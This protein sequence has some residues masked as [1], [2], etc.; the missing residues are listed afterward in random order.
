MDVGGCCYLVGLEFISN[1]RGGCRVG[2]PS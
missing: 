2:I 1:R